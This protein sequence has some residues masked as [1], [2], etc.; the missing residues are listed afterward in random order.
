MRRTYDYDAM[1]GQRFERL[2]LIG[3]YSKNNRIY[4][5]CKCVCGNTSHPTMQALLTGHSKSCGCLQREKNIERCTK[6]GLH[7][8]RI[9]RIYHLMIERCYLNTI[10]DYE[11]YGKRGIKVCDEWRGEKGF[12]NFYEWSMANGYNDTLTIDR[13]DVNGNYEPSN[14]RWTTMEV[15]NL[16]R[17]NTRYLTHNGITK[18]LVEWGKQSVCGVQIFRAR[19]QMGWDID[20]ALNTPKLM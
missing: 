7:K 19:I 14:C 5:E 6:H 13:I 12:E 3:Y 10:S 8:S 15:Q 9:Y 18:T 4:A 1:I 2:T 17:R 11:K 20:K 16:N